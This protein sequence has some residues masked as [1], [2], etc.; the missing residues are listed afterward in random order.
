[1]SW[2]AHL[3]DSKQC[4]S[5]NACT[6]LVRHSEAIQKI[7]SKK[8]MGRL[9]SVADLIKKLDALNQMMEKDDF[10]EKE[11]EFV[12]KRGCNQ[13]PIC[14]KPLKRQICHSNC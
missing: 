13:E 9:Y 12:V 5:T 7:G 11:F 1:M 3:R 10:L 8:C 4:F 2:S 6:G 14:K